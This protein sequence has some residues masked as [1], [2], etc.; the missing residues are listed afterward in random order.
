MKSVEISVEP[1]TVRQNDAVTVTVSIPDGGDPSGWFMRIVEAQG[2]T[3]VSPR[4][5]GAY[6]DPRQGAPGTY[7][8]KVHTIK[9]E[10][11]EYFVDL[12]TVVSFDPLE[13]TS[14]KFT[15]MPRRIIVATAGAVG[16]TDDAVVFGPSRDWL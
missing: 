1:D 5:L 15:V 10:P 9:F 7:D 16:P 2:T 11:G 8:C 4:K 14:K 6:G 13:T 12:S 3:K